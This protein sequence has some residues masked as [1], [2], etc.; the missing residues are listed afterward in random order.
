VQ[1]VHVCNYFSMS[2]TLSPRLRDRKKTETWA[3]IHEAAATLAHQHGAENASV[4]AIADSAGVSPRTFF[5]YFRTKEDAILGLREPVLDPELSSRLT[6]GDDL[7]DQVTRLLFTVARTAVGD[8][9]IVRRREL[10]KQDPNLFRRQLEY[11]AKA[12]ALVCEAVAGLLAGDP[13]W[14]GGAEDY[15]TA[16]TAR[17]LVL[18]AAVPARFTFTSPDFDPARGINLK[19]LDPALALLHHVQRKLP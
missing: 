10:L 15:S 7:L 14:S 11:L 19:D 2:D 12:E 4:T 18:L 17:M 3:A 16:E 1:E 13:S 8:S 6:T 5:N 9:D